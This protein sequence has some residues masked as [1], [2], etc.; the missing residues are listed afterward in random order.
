MSLHTRV[1]ILQFI[2]FVLRGISVKE[3]QY[4]YQNLARCCLSIHVC[5]LVVLKK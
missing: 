1:V 4:N 2:K 3:L 5:V